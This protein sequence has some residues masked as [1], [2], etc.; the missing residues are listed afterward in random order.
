MNDFYA[1]IRKNAPPN[2]PERLLFYWLQS[3][4]GQM[5][6][7]AEGYVAKHKEIVN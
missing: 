7:D 1:V 4:E 3:A 6:I 5:L 2:S